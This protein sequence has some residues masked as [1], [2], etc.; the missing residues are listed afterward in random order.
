MCTY[1][2][3]NHM[4]SISDL[5]KKSTLKFLI[6]PNVF[7]FCKYIFCLGNSFCGIDENYKSRNKLHF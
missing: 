4:C 1:Y 3:K 7:T 2:D 6:G 5:E